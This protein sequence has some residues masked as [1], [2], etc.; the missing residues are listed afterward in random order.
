MYGDSVFINIIGADNWTYIACIGD[1]GELMYDPIR[2]SAYSINDLVGGHYIVDQ[3][4]NHIN[5]ID[6][7][8]GTVYATITEENSRPVYPTLGGTG[9]VIFTAAST[10]EN[11]EYFVYNIEGEKIIPHVTWKKD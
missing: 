3:E 10:G 4:D 8:T 6:L 11:V 5:I 7:M 9:N 1:L 2:T